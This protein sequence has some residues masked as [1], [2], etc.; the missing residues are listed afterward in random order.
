[1]SVSASTS[2]ILD[3]LPSG[4]SSSSD[5]LDSLPDS[6]DSDSIDS[7]V[8]ESDAEREWKESLEQLELL[9]TMVIV[10]YLGKYFGR[11]CAYWGEWVTRGERDRGCAVADVLILCLMGRLGK[12]HG[13]E[14][15]GGSCRYEQEGF[16]GCWD[17]RGGVI[18]VTRASSR[19]RL[20]LNWGSKKSSRAISKLLVYHQLLQSQ[21]SH[22]VVG[23]AP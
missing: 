23:Q 16:Q 20:Q 22:K 21:M 15:P 9:L 4:S 3:D 6:A 8:E 5:E 1:M 7:D 11:K 18:G 10:P 14:I 13:V 19:K 17:S 2:Y 12:V